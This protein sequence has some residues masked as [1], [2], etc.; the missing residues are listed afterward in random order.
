MDYGEI[1]ALTII[2]IGFFQVLYGVCELIKIIREKLSQKKI[3][4]GG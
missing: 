3:R 4:N 1:F 2:A